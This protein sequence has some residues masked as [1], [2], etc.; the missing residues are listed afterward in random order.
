MSAIGTKQTSVC[1]VTMSAV[2]VNRILDG[3]SKDCPRTLSQ[4]L[5]LQPDQRNTSECSRAHFR[6][7]FDRAQR[8]CL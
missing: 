2:E 7:G 5:Q 6:T 4:T 1:V 3:N 8:E